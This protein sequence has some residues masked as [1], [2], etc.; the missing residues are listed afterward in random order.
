VGVVDGATPA[1]VESDADVADRKAL[2]RTLGYK[3]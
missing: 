1:G 3:L 2:L